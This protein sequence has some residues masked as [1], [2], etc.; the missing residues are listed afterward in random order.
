MV[1]FG[2][3]VRSLRMARKW[4][5][6][7]LATVLNVK[8]NT[9]SN[10]ETGTSYPDFNSL[11]SIIKLFEISADDLLFKDLSDGSYSVQEP[12]TKYVGTATPEKNMYE[13]RLAEK[14]KTIAALEE[15]LTLYKEIVNNLKN[16]RKE[17]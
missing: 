15:T 14:D 2:G 9:V 17:V 16:N 12:R 11:V 3:N 4:S 7:K 13:Q 8:P 6:E 10:Y 1:Y 5:Q